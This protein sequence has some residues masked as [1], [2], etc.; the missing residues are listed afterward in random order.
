[1]HNEVNV[2]DI[3]LKILYKIDN[4][5]AYSNLALDEE[6]NKYHL[7]KRDKALF[8]KL[9]YGTLTYL[10]TLDKIIEKY[11]NIKLKKISPWILNILR[12]GIYQI[13][14]LDKIP[15]P[16]IVNESVNLAKK[17]G[18][19]A[20]SGFVN[21]ILKRIESNELQTLVF[22]NDIEKISILTSHP[23]WLV[24]L[25]INEYDFDTVKSICEYNNI[26]APIYIRTNTLKLSTDE[27]ISMLQQNGI[28]SEKTQ[29]QDAIK[30]NN[31]SDIANNE[32]FKQ[33]YFT[34]Q[35]ASATL[36]SQILNV[37]P[38]ETIL[39][40]CSAPGGKT[41]HIA[42]LMNNTGVIV[43]CDIYENRLKLVQD[44]ANRLGINV[45]QTQINDGT[46]FNPEYEGKFDRVLADVPCSG[47]GVIRRKIDIKYQKQIENINEIQ[48]IQYTILD[49]ASKYVKPNG[50]LVYSTCTILKQENENV[51]DKFLG[52]NP[53]FELVD[54]SN[55][56]ENNY[57][58]EKYIKALPHIHNFDG[59]FIAKLV[60]KGN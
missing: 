28:E 46:I 32:L 44:T 29:V 8:T 5:N 38:N 48:D 56:L 42:Q 4:Q 7:E 43:A 50:I 58:K 20:S 21:A 33:G 12:M 9:V 11:S 36:V 1:M 49:N 54:I 55:M 2:R 51:I 57:A 30:L 47:L 6:L 52:N 18:H 16:A 37:K 22:E 27:L 35:D 40:I 23:Q 3:A 34:I 31:L 60:R 45:I 25:L 41:T 13:L 15:K 53:D 19:K 24:E 39:D 26:E 10:I 14:Y 17:Y 59:F